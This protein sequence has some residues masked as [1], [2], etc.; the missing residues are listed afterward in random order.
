[1]SDNLPPKILSIMEQ[2]NAGEKNALLTALSDPD[3]TAAR[4]TRILN[5]HGHQVGYTTCKQAR[6]ELISK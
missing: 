1:M 4:V 6:A 5:K 2:L 3:D